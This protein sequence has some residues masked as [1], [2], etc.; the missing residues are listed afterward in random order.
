LPAGP[1]LLPDRD[2]RQSLPVYTIAGDYLVKLLGRIY[3]KDPDASL[4]S[5]YASWPQIETA[6][7][8]QLVLFTRGLSPFH[9]APN[10]STERMYWESLC[11]V[12]AADLLAHLGIIFT[13]VVPNSMAE[14]R[15]MSTLTK[16]NSPDRASQKVS[17][18]IDMASIRQHYKREESHDSPVGLFLA[19]IYY[20]HELIP[21]KSSHSLLRPTVRFA[22][23]S[24]AAGDVMEPSAPVGASYTD[25]TN[26]EGTLGWFDTE[27]VSEDLPFEALPIVRG[28][29]HHFEVEQTDGVTLSSKWISDLIYDSLS[30]GTKRSR[31]PEPLPADT[32][33]PKKRQR[34][35]ISTL[36][37]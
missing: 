10:P 11:A 16:L 27:F 15:S 29:P 7:R 24:H 17:T 20:I 12:P 13:S 2:L 25:P 35:D 34:V 33:L 21:F 9:R 23:L 37:Y 22:D 31:S 26:I 36:A 28:N 3:N 8:N 1:E 5:R 30:I 32:P 6:F 4:F 18:L 19:F 14:E